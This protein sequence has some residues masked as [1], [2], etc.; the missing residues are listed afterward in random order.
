LINKFCHICPR[1]LKLFNILASSDPSSSLDDLPACTFNSVWE[2]RMK[3]KVLLYQESEEKLQMYYV[4][5]K[6]LKRS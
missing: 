1:L 5:Q 6:E 4:L 3:N 2:V